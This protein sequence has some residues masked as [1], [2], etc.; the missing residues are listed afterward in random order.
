MLPSTAPET[1]PSF[2][3]SP[4]VD[5]PV[6]VS[7]C[8]DDDADFVYDLYYRDTREALPG[9]LAWAEDVGSLAGLQRIGEL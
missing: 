2:S 8:D 6:S 5:E 9:T 4:A 7:S 1:S 3:A